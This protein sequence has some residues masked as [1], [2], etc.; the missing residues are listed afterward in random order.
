MA[1]ATKNADN[2]ATVRHRCPTC[3]GRGR[4]VETTCETCGRCFPVEQWD[5]DDA[6]LPCGHS[7]ETLTARQVTCSS[8]AG[9]G[10]VWVVLSP[11]ASQSW[12]RRRR[13]RGV[14]LF[15]L[16]LVPLVLLGIAMYYRD[17]A[18]ICGSWWY[19]T[20]GLLLL[21]AFR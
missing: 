5:H 1:T 18:Y 12:R 16:A 7:S 19:G 10:V 3:G 14:T 4:V 8:C 13:A 20:A 11:S 6:L 17:P 15:L 2:S 9:K 21:L